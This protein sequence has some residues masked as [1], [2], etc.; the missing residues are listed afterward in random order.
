MD[1]Q[2]SRSFFLLI[3]LADSYARD[4]AFLALYQVTMAGIAAAP[5]LRAVSDSVLLLLV[6]VWPCGRF[7][8]LWWR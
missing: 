7:L 6:P 3:Q 2:A 8:L 4:D 5:G 1:L